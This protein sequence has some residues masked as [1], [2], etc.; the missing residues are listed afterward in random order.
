MA[1]SCMAPHELVLQISFGTG[2][3]HAEPLARIRLDL[4][5]EDRMLLAPP[6]ASGSFAG[7]WG[8]A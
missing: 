7:V 2:F 8:D 6:G 5:Q 4:A 3:Y 1:L